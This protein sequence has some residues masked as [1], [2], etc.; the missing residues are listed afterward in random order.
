M[1]EVSARNLVFQRPLNVKEKP[2][3]RDRATFE[4]HHLGSGKTKKKE[5][6]LLFVGNKKQ[7]NYG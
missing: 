6:F 7:I 4:S 1:A 3:L 5:A 2:K